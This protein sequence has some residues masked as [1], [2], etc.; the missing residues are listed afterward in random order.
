MPFFLHLRT[1]YKLALGFG[2]SLLCAISI[3]FVALSRMQ[4]MQ[5]ATS[6]AASLEALQSG[7]FLIFAL[8]TAAIVCGSLIAAAVTRYITGTLSQMSQRLEQLSSVDVTRLGT[9]IT[10]MEFGDLSMPVRYETEPL[11]ISSRDEFGQMGTTINLLMNQTHC[12]IQSFR[13]SRAGLQDLVRTLQQ[14]A[15]QVAQTAGTLTDTSGNIGAGVEQIGAMMMDIA[16]SSDQSAH[17]AAEVAQGAAQQS[18]SMAEGTKLLDQ[19]SGI[20]ET[21]TSEAQGARQAAGE[22][23]AVAS[24]GVEAVAQTVQGMARIRASVTESAGV[25]ASLGQS[26]REIGAI[27]K[28]IDEIAEQT[29]LLALNA[30]IEAARAGEAGRGFAV[31]ASEVRRLAERA[32]KATGEITGLINE[33]Q[34]HTQKAVSTMETGAREVELGA[35]LAETAGEALM[36]IQDVVAAVTERV[37]GIDVSAQRMTT[38]SARVSESIHTMAHLVAQSGEM[39]E[40]MS[41]AAA[42]VSSSVR[43]VSGAA[44]KQG[45]AAGEMI[46]FSQSLTE[47]ACTLEDAVSQFQVEAAPAPAFREPLRLAA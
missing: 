30:A 46:A 41:A 47:I 17:G 15:A 6:P 28:T 44:A 5:Q 43:T 23:Q 25:V 22:A 14:N 36:K 37:A 34:Q 35:Q 20:I 16:R 1:G 21:V 19:L 12:T 32:G 4:A 10:V 3:A 33:V 13:A 2:F 8:L 27:V 39:A 45:S 26:S 7:R 24:G 9:A 18:R 29:N 11:E 40:Q 31:V 42:Q 38:S